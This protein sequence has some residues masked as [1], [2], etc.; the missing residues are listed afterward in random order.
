MSSDRKVLQPS[1]AFQICVNMYVHA[2]GALQY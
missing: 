2:V 1:T